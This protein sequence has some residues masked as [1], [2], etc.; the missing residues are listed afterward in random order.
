MG[1]VEV[2]WRR[3]RSK[4]IFF[5]CLFIFIL[6]PILSIFLATIFGGLLALAESTTFLKGFLY[7]VSNLLGMANPLT[8]W[9]P[10]SGT[11]VVVVIDLYTAVAAL[12]SFG[13]MLNIVNLFGIPHSMNKF[14]R[15]CT[16]N[17]VLV[18]TIALGIIIP[19]L[20]TT[21]CVIFGTILA[22]IEGWTISD[23]ILYVITNILGLADP[24]TD[25]MPDTKGGKV[26]DII[27][28]STA[29][30]YIAIFAD[31]VTTLN[32]S[33]YV[34]KHTRLLLIKMGAVDKQ[35]T[36]NVHPLHLDIDNEVEIGNGESATHARSIL[37]GS[38]PIDDQPV[39]AKQDSSSC[40]KGY[41]KRQTF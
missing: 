26:V 36:T 38:F 20:Y 12:I 19:I 39:T 7:V 22:L 3:S 31:Y 29:L 11:G 6:F 32:P 41:Y 10:T 4:R 5:L 30:G 33:S 40:Q 15:R 35:N 37:S 13:I 9:V 25:I 21:I 8:D 28:S 34:R 17:E 2:S 18:P 16:K 1:T 27:I 24:L 14:I 23:G